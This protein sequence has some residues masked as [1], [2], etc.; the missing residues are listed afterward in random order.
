MEHSSSSPEQQQPSATTAAATASRTT[1]S[2][3]TATFAASATST[4]TTSSTS[5]FRSTSSS[6]KPQHSTSSLFSSTRSLSSS[7]SSMGGSTT[8]AM[9]GGG[10][11]ENLPPRTLARVAR[12]VRDLV[13]SPP[14]GVR[15]VVDEESGMPGS[16]AEIVAEIE[17]PEDTP[18]HT[19]YFQLK[20][21]LST[22]FPSKPPRGYFLTKIYHPNVDPTTGAICVNTLK[23]DWTPTTSLSHVLTVI[24][25]LMI[26]P[27]PESSLNDEAGKNFMDSYDEYAKRARLLAGVHGLTRWSSAPIMMNGA[28]NMSGGEGKTPENDSDNEDM[29]KKK[30]QH[31]HLDGKKSPTTLPN[32]AVDNSGSSPGKKLK[33]SSHHSN[34]VRAS[35]NGGKSLDKKSKKKS[36][37]RL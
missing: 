20:L 21:V 26:V 13:K 1:S 22:D 18:Y 16:L 27:F 14:E 5:L 10:C 37:K 23:K 34:I 28:A 29:T 25:C 7:T 30:Q 17:G 4:T 6:I 31:H 19:R 32:N 3:T 24:R 2:S 33:K 15:L 36:L 12:D 35:G 8:I 9:G 11:G